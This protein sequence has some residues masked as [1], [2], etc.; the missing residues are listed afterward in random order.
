MQRVQKQMQENA[1]GGSTD[2]AAAR[3]PTKS[4]SAA[5]K[6]YQNRVAYSLPQLKLCLVGEPSRAKRLIAIQAPEDVARFLNPLRYAAEEHFVSIH[7]NARHEVLGLHEVSHG[8]LSASLVHPREVFKAAILANSYAIIVCHNH[9]SGSKVVPSKEDLETTGQLFNAGKLLGV[10][11]ID[12]LIVGPGLKKNTVY[13][14]R[15]HHPEFWRT[16]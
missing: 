4:K 13:S 15:E 10:T 14:I 6:R 8:S 5:R 7:L 9:P 11:L 12:H 3:F 1:V 16:S 2:A